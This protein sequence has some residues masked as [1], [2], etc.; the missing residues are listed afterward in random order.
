MELNSSKPVFIQIKEYYERL[1]D[2]SS[3][4][5][6]DEMPSVREIA[7]FFKVNPNTAQRALTLLVEEG[8]LRNVPKKGFYVTRPNMDKEKVIRYF[9]DEMEK[10]G[11]SK[12]ELKDYLNKE[13]EQ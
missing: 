3:L 10:S 8:Y 12:E 2:S 1:I 4:K 13:D 9:L 5:E 7:L 6:G 11:I